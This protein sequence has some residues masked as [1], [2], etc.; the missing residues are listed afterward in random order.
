MRAFLILLTVLL[1][2]P[3]SADP[4]L[5]VFT[6]LGYLLNDAAFYPPQLVNTDFP[7]GLL[8]LRVDEGLRVNYSLTPRWR[9]GAQAG[10]AMIAGSGSSSSGEVPFAAVSIPVEVSAQYGQS[11]Y[12][13]VVAGYLGQLSLEPRNVTDATG[14]LQGLRLGWADWY[15][16]VEAVYHVGLIASPTVR[17]IVGYEGWVQ[18]ITSRLRSE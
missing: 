4:E 1:A 2:A 7:S 6:G 5:V 14:F 12:I 10:F 16:S 17:I 3:L 9:V 18:L 15:C 11:P 13:A 8:H